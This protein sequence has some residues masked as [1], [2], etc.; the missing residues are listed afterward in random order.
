[1]P[2]D[3]GQN[4][5]IHETAV[6]GEDVV[7]GDRVTIGPFVVLTGPLEI[8]SDCWIGAQAVLGAPPE[9]NGFEH[10][11][12]YSEP[13]NG[14]GIFIGENTVIRELSAVHQGSQRRTLTGANS[15]TMNRISVGHDVQLGDNTIAAPGVTFGGHVTLG[16]G[17]NMGM[18]STIH[19]RRVVG[20]GAMVGM[21]GIATKDVPPF[22]T[23]VGNPGVLHGANTVGMTRKGY[24]E[25][26]I[27][28]VGSAYSNCRLP[29]L[30][31]LNETTAAAFEWWRNLSTKPLIT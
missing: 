2:I 19:Q 3:I 15:F 17:C 10:F 23:V 29:D 13:S 1:M 25:S 5:R 22:A 24:A 31:A 18:N 21:G 30:A 26:D 14:R 16:P 11:S 6:I 7:I 27:E 20:A 8:S 28:V 12:S 4:C 9:I